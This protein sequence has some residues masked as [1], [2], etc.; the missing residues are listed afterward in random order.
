MVETTPAGQQVAVQ[1]ADKKT[2]AGSLFGLAVAPEG[3]GIYFVDDG[4]NTLNFLHEGQPA[5][6]TTSST[7]AAPTATTTTPATKSVS[8]AVR[9]LPTVGA[10]LVNAE[11]HTLYTFAPDQHS[12]VTCVSACASLWPPLKLASGETAAGPSQLKASLLGSDP[13]PEGGS[14]VTYAGW[15]LYTYAADSAAGQDNGQALEADGG[16]WY[17]IA[18]SGKVIT[19]H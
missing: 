2:G 11:G 4:E 9:T 3:K 8:L 14:V 15:P 6:P 13:D 7:A 18:P 16:L 10:V 12:K 17:V 19:T 5:T 1:T